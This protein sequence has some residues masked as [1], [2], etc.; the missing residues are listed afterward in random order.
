[1]NIKNP[2]GSLT[3]ETALI[4]PLIVYG[5]LLMI[6]LILLTF[7]RIGAAISVNRV[8]N[9]ITGTYFDA[10]GRYGAYANSGPSGGIITEAIAEAFTGTNRK[11][12]VIKEVL[13]KE[14]ARNSPIKLEVD[15]SKVDAKNYI[16]WQ[17]VDM[18]IKVKYPLILAGV[19]QVFGADDRY[20]DGK[21]EETHVRHVVVSSTESNIRTIDYLG[22]KIAQL[23]DGSN[24][25]NKFDTLIGDIKEKIASI[26]GS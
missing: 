19:F 24:F 12:D 10:Y 13:E 9:E 16:L 5:I 1:M 22:D 6:F 21:F 14:I 23:Y 3:V 8:C 4:F 26:F 20:N 25:K 15:V 7:S 11:E 17:Q 2:K 18:E